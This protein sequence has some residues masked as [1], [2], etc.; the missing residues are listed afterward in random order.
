MY[1]GD[2]IL[3]I[4]IDPKIPFHEPTYGNGFDPKRTFHEPTYDNDLEEMI[5]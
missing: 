4:D 1:F 5:Q 2:D 3:I